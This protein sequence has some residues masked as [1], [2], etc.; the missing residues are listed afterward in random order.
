[1]TDKDTI[2]IKAPPGTKARWVRRAGGEKLGD[3]LIRQIDAP[4]ASAEAYLA[5]FEPRPEGDVAMLTE[6]QLR[7]AMRQAYLAGSRRE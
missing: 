7:D 6:A 5:R 2:I 3:W 4:P 1:M